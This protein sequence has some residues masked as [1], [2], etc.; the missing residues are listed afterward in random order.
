MTLI[1]LAA[2]C[3]TTA[4]FVPQVIQILKTKN[5]EGI[6]LGM[7]AIFTLGVAL[8]LIYAT[9]I[10]DLPMLL[11]NLVT[12]VLSGGVLTLTVRSRLRAGRTSVND[13]N[14]ALP[15]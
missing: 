3:L 10:G 11:A 4:A 12:L 13:D 15:R 7:Y 1:G 9:I 14:L 2:A 8:W 5:V 6:S